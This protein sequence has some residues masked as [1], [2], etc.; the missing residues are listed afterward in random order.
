MNSVKIEMGAI[1]SLRKVIFKHDLM[2]DY[3]ND[4]DKEPSWDGFIYLYK[5]DD[6]RAENIK[7]KIPVQVKGKNQHN[8]L[9]RQRISYQV[10]YKHLRNYYNDGGVF[11]VVVIISDDGE[12]ESIFYNSLTAIKLAD[13]LR[14]TE[15]KM[16]D[17]KKS[18]SLQRL[19]KNDSDKLY[20]VLAQ[21]GMDRE[22]Q[23]SGNGEIVKKAIDISV[24][25]C[26]DSIQATSYFAETETEMLKAI[27]TGEISL[28]GHRADIDMWLPF[29]YSQQK[30]I[31]FKQIV[32]MDKTISVDGVI[33]YDSY[34][35][36][37]ESPED[38]KPIIR[39]SEN[40]TIDLYR[41]KFHFEVNGNLDTL[42]KDIRV[43]E[44][45]E[46]G[47]TFCVNDK[48]V[49]EFIDVKVPSNLK[50]KIK[51]IQDVNA[52]FIEIGFKCNKKFKDFT[53][54]NWKSINEV[55]NLY[56][57]NIRPKEG[58]HNAW[59][60]WY[61]DGRVV[62]VFL[63]NNRDGEADVVNWFTTEKYV[64]FAGEDNRYI[65]PRFILFKRD[66]L[67]KLYDVDE[68]IWFDEIERIEYTEEICSAL[69]E[70]FIELVSAY[71]INHN[72]VYYNAAKLMINKVLE[73]FPEDECGII[74]N[75]QLLKRKRELSEKEIIK[76]EKID[77]KSDNLMTKCAINI[78]LENKRK[79]QKLMTELSEENR[80][81]MMSYPIYNLL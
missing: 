51:M 18:I 70:F 43:I 65:L 13:L 41:G 49:L 9:Y 19:E 22:K 25:D 30:G 64:L 57:R 58:K 53:D 24:M 7:Y 63:N 44:A 45:V 12:K 10:E 42:L 39:V 56:H 50:D 67:E 4:N 73:V 79:A 37:G 2:H 6:L 78:L 62:P 38:D 40:M 3:I 54:E 15:D 26:V 47:K 16:P 21:F 74:N 80:R 81:K 52:A 59:Y 35:V 32:K 17:Q 34:L 31:V 61:W 69:Y 28:Y 76:L 14:N 33:Y 60:M 23:G 27:A 5:S 68:K 55:L 72:E 77:E 29:D 20:K 48:K 36:E 46:R 71:D 8:L 75:M 11:Y 1:L 66:I